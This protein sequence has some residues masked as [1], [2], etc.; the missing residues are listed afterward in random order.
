MTR[1]HCCPVCRGTGKASS[2]IVGDKCNAC[3]GDGF[4]WEPQ[5]RQSEEAKR[6]G[7][8]MPGQLDLTYDG[9]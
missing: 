3:K 4:L 8:P 6:D 5:S 9:E 7:G 2:V 1:P